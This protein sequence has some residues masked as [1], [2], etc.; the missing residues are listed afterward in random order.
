ML[1][2]QHDGNVMVV[3]AHVCAAENVMP[4]WEIIVIIAVSLALGV[5]LGVAIHRAEHER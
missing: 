1:V 3:D 5:P 2:V 4:T